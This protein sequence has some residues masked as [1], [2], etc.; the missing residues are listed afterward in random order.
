M[1]KTRQFDKAFAI[2][3]AFA[4]AILA[5]N[6]VIYSAP[7]PPPRL[8]RLSA[9][10]DGPLDVTHGPTGLVT[11][12]RGQMHEPIALGA[13]TSQMTDVSTQA[14]AFVTSYADV[15][16]IR[17]AGN[18]L[19]VTDVTT[20]DLGMTHVTLQQVYDG[21]PVLDAQIKQ[22]FSADGVTLVAVSSS[23][24]PGVKLA[25]VKPSIG[26]GQAIA[27]SK[28]ALANGVL[29]LA[30]ALAIY[31]AHTA[32]STT[33]RLVWPVE[34]LDD[35]IPA[36]NVYY[37]DAQT[38]MIVDVA[39]KLYVARNRQTYNLNGKTSLPGTLARTESQAAT[40]DRDVDNAHD[41]A[42]ATYDYFKNVHNRDGFDNKGAAIISSV[43]YGRNYNNAFWN[44]EQMVYGDGFPV[45]DVI[46]HEL[47]HAVT[48]RTANL[49]YKW[50]SGAINESLSDIFG[51]MVDRDD[52]VMGED[53]PPDALGGR[54]GIRDL[55]NPKRFG[56]PDN[57]SDWVRTCSDNEGVHTNSGI[58]N[59]A[60]YNIALTLGKEK[61]ERIFYRALT[62]YLRST[63]SLEDLRAKALQS[64]QDLYGANSAEV[65][66]VRNGFNAVGINGTWN[67]SSN[68]CSCAATVAVSTNSIFDDTLTAIESAATLYRVRDQL[69]SA[70]PAGR[71]YRNLYYQHTGRMSALMLLDASVRESGA[72]VVQ[73][74][75]PGLAHLANGNGDQAVVDAGLVANAR[76]Y[77][78]QI[79][80]ADR[81]NGGGELASV[82]DQEM[83]RIEW[84]KL[85]GMNYDQAWAYVNSHL[86]FVPRNI[87]LPVLTQ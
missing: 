68:D 74:L 59:K 71:Y 23:Y 28:R 60:F 49:Q 64:T 82:I 85:V 20:D 75:A 37:I 12:I 32:V 24:V 36:R 18:E 67:P 70:T 50:Q 65:T 1:M 7:A 42:G 54:E 34:L 69:L 26:A 51:A 52:W 73:Q 39:D 61:A 22:H 29:S 83:K 63:S 19:V 40:G 80:D 3:L 41:F 46:G 56:Q 31:A 27:T 2:T 53:L 11:F 35:S 47:T 10:A 33:S 84:D 58:P 21:V 38:G 15:F 30:P 44:G 9:N 17:D 16:G 48:E 25:S 72:R 66:G 77:L 78:T 62:I 87:Y 4:I 57:A 79:V 6:S 81:R 5:N 14:L 55:A 76:S 43:H 8:D 13:T 86:S 45:K